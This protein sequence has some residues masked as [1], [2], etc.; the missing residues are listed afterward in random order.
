MED[1]SLHILDIAENS[2]SN[3]A[4]RIEIRIEENPAKNVLTIEIAD[5]GKGK[6]EQ[7]LRKVLDL[8]LRQKRHAMS[9]GSQRIAF[10]EKERRLHPLRA[11]HKSL[12]GANGGGRHQLRQQRTGP[13][14]IRP[15]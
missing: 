1:T 10:S 5:D 15:L 7:T 3:S 6:D 12:R 2:I 8:F 14:D 9:D 11:L 13:E 4:K